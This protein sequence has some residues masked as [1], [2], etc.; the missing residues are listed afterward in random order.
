MF[1]K[2][3]LLAAL[4]LGIAVGPGLAQLQLKRVARLPLGSVWPCY[5]LVLGDTD[6]DGLGEII[7]WTSRP[8]RWEIV[9][10]RPVN[11]YEVV[12][13]LVGMSPVPESIVI[14]NFWPYDIGDIDRD[15]RTDLVGKVLYRQGSE[16]RVALCTVESRDSISYPDSLN[17]WVVTPDLAVTC[18]ALLYTDLDRDSSLEILTQWGES[19]AVFENVGDDRESLVCTVPVNPGEARFTVGDYDQNGRMDYAFKWS[20]ETYVDEYQGGHNYAQVCSIYTGTINVYDRFGGHD[21]DR[22]GRPEW[23]EVNVMGVGGMR[24]RHALYQFE[25]TGEHT[26]TCDSVDTATSFMNARG[27]SLCAD[28]D[29]DSLEE[30]VWSVGDRIH[31]LKATGPH[32]YEKVST[33]RRDSGVISVCNAADF[34]GNGYKEIYVGGDSSSVVLEVECVRVMVPNGGQTFA[35]GDTC[36]IRWRVFTPPRC[37]SVSLFL[38]SDSI[39]VNRFYRLD[40]IAI[41]LSPSESTYSWVVPDT[42]LDSAWIVAIAYGPGWQFDESDRAFAV[43]P[44]GVAEVPQALPTAWSLAVG[45]NPARGALAVS[46]DVPHRGRVS[47]DVYDANGR[48]ALTLAEGLTMPGRYHMTLPPVTLPAGVYFVNLDTGDK[49]I[50]RK[51]VLTE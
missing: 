49:R 13:S 9:E 16:G 2:Y 3:R 20:L 31:V 44:S 4:L 21:V 41:G 11:R 6:R 18:E 50:S 19:T 28:V 8:L 29:G 45:P 15:G 12:Q 25:A 34:N 24:D 17:W 30:I 14:G 40:T 48:L 26:Y 22:N 39:T 10:L 1:R 7:Y 37:D 38:R 47:L 46:Y 27:R 5:R 33:W 35:P 32:Q 36:T 51:V 23:F 43:L 42:T